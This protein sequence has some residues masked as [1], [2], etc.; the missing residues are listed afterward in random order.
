MGHN[1]SHEQSTDKPVS[2][3]HHHKHHHHEP[4][5]SEERPYAMLLPIE[6]LTKVI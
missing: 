1:H 6:K 5:Q 2:S 4:A 3:S